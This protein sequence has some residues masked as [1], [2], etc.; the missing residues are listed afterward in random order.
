MKNFNFIFESLLKSFDE[1]SGI[2]YPHMNSFRFLKNAVLF[3]ETGIINEDLDVFPSEVFNR[4]LSFFNDTSN[5]VKLVKQ[6]EFLDTIDLKLDEE[7][8]RFKNDIIIVLKFNFKMY[9]ELLNCFRK[10]FSKSIE[11]MQNDPNIEEFYERLFNSS[12]S[13][14]FVDMVDENSHFSIFLLNKNEYTLNVVKHEM[15]HYLQNTFGVGIVN[16][17]KYLK[18]NTSNETYGLI[19]KDKLMQVFSKDDLIPYIHNICYEFEDHGIH[20][21]DDALKTLDKFLKYDG[22]P[23]EYIENCKSLNEYEWF[24]N[25]KTPIHMLMLSVIYRRNLNVLKVIIGKYFS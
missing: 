17:K 22:N 5:N 18:I 12:S 6:Y 10:V 24:I 9:S 1:K 21:L 8:N 23:K 20:T 14:A 16:N 25:E 15:I 13:A 2:S 19:S 7:K 11:E 3:D 4:T